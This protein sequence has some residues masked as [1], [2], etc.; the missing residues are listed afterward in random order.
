MWHGVGVEVVQRSRILCEQIQPLFTYGTHMWGTRITESIRIFDGL[1]I[2]FGTSG[3]ELE[4]LSKV[5]SIPSS[6]GSSVT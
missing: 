6:E 1:R 2:A 3:F 5:T 4:R